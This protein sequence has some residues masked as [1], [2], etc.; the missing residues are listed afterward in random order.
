MQIDKRIEAEVLEVSSHLGLPVCLLD[1]T[2]R[3]L[4]AGGGWAE[5]NDLWLDSADFVDGVARVADARRTYFLLESDNNRPLRI[6]IPYISGE[7]DRYGFL[8][9]SWLSEILK[10]T[11]KKPGKEEVFRRIML[12]RITPLDLQE[13]IRDYNIDSEHERCIIIIQSLVERLCQYTMH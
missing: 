2:G 13:A 1:E 7:V 4:V 9:I 11:L 6:M 10:S 5:E 3:V 12:D 8:I